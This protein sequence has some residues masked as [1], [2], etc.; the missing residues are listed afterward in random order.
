MFNLFRPTTHSTSSRSRGVGLVEAII[1]ASIISTAFV[2][3]VSAT[4]LYLQGG[5]YA[6]DKVRA[7]FLIE[8]GVEA[9][10]FLRDEGYAAHITPLVGVGVRYLDP[11]AGGWTVTTT[12]TPIFGA[13]T[14][15]IL[16]E[17][18]YRRNSDKDIVPAT[19]GDPK[20]IDA[21]TV[22]I[23]VAVSWPKGSAQTVSYLSDIYEN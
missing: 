4:V 8:E 11:V 19:S 1:V 6:A 3:L 22:K 23:T 20:S 9:V 14:R 18:V 16:V 5:L 17:Q 7:V 2:A 21:G 10:R 13:F 15:T 12:N